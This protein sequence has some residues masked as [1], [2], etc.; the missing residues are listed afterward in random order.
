MTDNGIKRKIAILGGG[1]GAMT[2]AFELTNVEGWQDRY[3]VTIYQMGWRC[4]GKGASGRRM[5]RYARIEEH[6]LHVWLGFYENA[7]H[8]IRNAYAEV[9]R[10]NL[11]PD[12]PFRDWTDAFSP[13][14]LATVLEQTPEGWTPWSIRW[15]RNDGVPGE[16]ELFQAPQ[17]GPTPA[18]DILSVT[19]WLLERFELWRGHSNSSGGAGH[20]LPFWLEEE[21]R[22]ISVNLEPDAELT[23]KDAPFLTRFSPL[24]LAHEVAQKIFGGGRDGAP[25]QHVPLLTGLLAHAYQ[26]LKEFVEQSAER[27]PEL[28][29]L[30]K[31]V[32]LAR[33]L[34][35]G[36]V[37]D[38]VITN[39]YE[40]INQYDIAEWL[41]GHGSQ[42]AEELLKSAY[43]ACFGFEHGDPTRPN[44]EAG[45][46]L[47]GMMRG[48]FSYRGALMWRM[49]A[50]MGDAIFAP[51][52]L[53]LR[54]RGV[55][56]QFFHLVRN[57]GLSADR[58]HI[59]TID[60]DVQATLKPEI[61]AQGKSYDPL[62]TV[63]G[64]PCWPDRPLY[65]Q[66]AEGEQLKSFNLE[67]AYT[68]W[69]SKRATL[70]FGTD[71]D[72]VVLATSLGPLPY[73]CPEL[74]RSDDRWREMIE[75]IQTVQTQS[76][77][78]WL[79]RTA[80]ELGSQVSVPTIPGDLRTISAY[81]EPFDTYAD[82]S[83]LIDREL[84]PASAG[85]RQVAYF[86]NAMPDPESGSPAPFSD[87]SFPAREQEQVKQNALEFLRKSIRPIW[88]NFEWSDLI[89]LEERQDEHRFDAQVWRANI[90]PSERYVL[91]LRGTSKYR[92]RPDRSGFENLVLAGDW[93][94]NVINAG[95]VEA[96][97]ISGRIAARALCGHPRYIYGAYGDVMQGVAQRR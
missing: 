95:C 85:V 21:L 44:M 62:V 19:H 71:F 2:C 90:D 83:Q 10:H 39:G 58:R 37:L 70:R 78:L 91:S 33:A 6:G 25:L 30:I 59:E 56:F 5:D 26:W 64:L 69:K 46:T 50:G 93:T 32:D 12:S 72:Q 60:V 84:W 18:D 88:P 42:H 7:F 24:H 8:V 1:V 77:Q 68:E 31:T 73:I 47:Y 80:A 48:L 54:T 41:K 55:Q 35:S 17:S 20:E 89:D 38:D 86:C 87:A 96:A 13:Q 40:S 63:K 16:N 52:Y 3:D 79:K 22:L 14:S 11:A 97:V 53:V 94:Y 92:L 75:N 15:P 23:A 4:G 65:D 51:L 45:T 9:A 76:V 74:I 49:N 34:V 81:V 43:D 82:M 66:L 67:S 57:L 36:M 27:D 61:E 29:H 28:R